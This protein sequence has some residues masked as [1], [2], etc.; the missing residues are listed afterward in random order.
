M[1]R[2]TTRQLLHDTEALRGRV[3]PVQVL[4][5]NDGSVQVTIAHDAGSRVCARRLL[6][7]L[8]PLLLA[9]AVG[10][11]LFGLS[12]GLR[13]GIFAVPFGWLG[14]AMAIGGLV[15]W[16]RAGRIYVF[17]VM[18]DTVSADSTGMFGPRHWEWPRA[19]VRD[20]CIASGREWYLRF[21]LAP[22]WL[23]RRGF[24][25]NLRREDLRVVA[26]ALREGLGF[27][28]LSE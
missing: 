28:L 5:G 4:R 14:I 26:N 19:G 16:D 10:L 20:V 15:A 18:R 11:L 7:Y 8:A 25:L 17:R 22:G 6:Q 3:S 13:I 27:A 21:D 24:A 9:I 1:A 12:L 2:G 23:N